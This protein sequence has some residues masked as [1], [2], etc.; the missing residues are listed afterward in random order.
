MRPAPIP[1]SRFRRQIESERRD[2]EH[3][4]NINREWLGRDDSN[5]AASAMRIFEAMRPHGMG[6]VYVNLLGD[7]RRGLRSIGLLVREI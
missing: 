2:A 3:A 6:R 7:E 5:E 1:Q 4:I